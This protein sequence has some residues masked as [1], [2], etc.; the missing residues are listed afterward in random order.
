MMIGPGLF[1]TVREQLYGLGAAGPKDQKT[2]S[3]GTEASNHPKN[4][5]HRVAPSDSAIWQYDASRGLDA[6]T[7]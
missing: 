7:G 3:G 4:T 5:F 6:G 1:E 2:S